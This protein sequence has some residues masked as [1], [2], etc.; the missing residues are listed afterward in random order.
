MP[1]DIE[2]AAIQGTPLVYTRQDFLDALL[3]HGRMTRRRLAF[4]SILMVALVA[5]C[6][7]TDS[8]EERLTTAAAA[9]LGGVVFY[10]LGR[11]LYYPWLAGRQFSKQP[12]STLPQTVSLADDGIVFASE[13]GAMRLLWSDFF[14]WD[15]N[16]RVII[17][18]TSPR[19][20]MIIP[21][22]IA[23]NGFPIEKMK[24]ALET[25]LGAR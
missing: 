14:G 12:L 13:R 19:L 16:D 7:V 24:R 18:K 5:L 4:F 17:L 8:W 25:S 6:L 1:D 10:L 9:A 2:N 23:A 22:R 20:F 11:Y 15:A 21:S 3:L